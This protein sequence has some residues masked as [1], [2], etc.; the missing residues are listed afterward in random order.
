MN[1][2]M[3]LPLNQNQQHWKA[4][5]NL[6]FLKCCFLLQMLPSSTDISQ[7]NGQ[8]QDRETCVKVKGMTESTPANSQQEVDSTCRS[9]ITPNM[10][11]AS[12]ITLTSPEKV[13]ALHEKLRQIHHKNC[14]VSKNLFYVSEIY[15]SWQSF[16]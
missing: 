6:N 8:P 7:A 14:Q 15:Y 2:P 9:C 3:W 1:S 10:Y 4:P 11:D 16:C 13:I 5:S 12:P